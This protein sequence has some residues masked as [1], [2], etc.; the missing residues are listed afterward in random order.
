[1]FLSCPRPL[2]RGLARIRLYAYTLLGLRESSLPDLGFITL[3]RS[4]STALSQNP[5]PQEGSTWGL[6]VSLILLIRILVQGGWGQHG[7]FLIKLLSRRS[8]ISRSCP[9]ASTLASARDARAAAF[10]IPRS[11]WTPFGSYIIIIAQVPRNTTPR[12]PQA[13]GGIYG[14]RGGVSQ[15]CFC[16]APAPCLEDLRV[17]AY[18][19]ILS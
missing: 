6:D 4:G 19:H 2:L 17:Y 5:L 18:M 7:P 14:G 3:C 11:N 15:I 9:Q 16:R 13:P 10:D 12:T 8:E 1:M